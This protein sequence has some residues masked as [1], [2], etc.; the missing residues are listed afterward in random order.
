[1]RKL[2][3]GRVLLRLLSLIPKK[4]P[5]GKLE[6]QPFFVVSAGRSGSN[7][8]NRLL[9]E[10]SQL[11]LPTEQTFLPDL[12]IKFRLYNWILWRDLSKILAGELVLETNTWEN[13]RYQ[14]VFKKIVSAKGTDRHMVKVIDFIFRSFE[15]QLGCSKKYWGDTTHLNLR[16]TKEIY[17]AFPNAKFI[18]LVRDGRDVVA[19]Y[20]E[21]AGIEEYMHLKDHIE[22]AK[23]WE[24]AFST[25]KWLSSKT[26]VHQVKY[27]DL[28]SNPSAVMARVFKFLRVGN[29]SVKDFQ[30]N[31]PDHSFYKEAYHVN[32]KKPISDSSVGKWQSI[33]THEEMTEI[34]PI[35]QKPMEDLG[36]MGN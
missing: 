2:T 12:I 16:Y 15:T 13:F 10:H 3:L 31:I 30:K 22:V 6:K 26:E 24:N 9:N 27:E 33:L 7:L 1:M 17:G 36:Y 11:F 34:T 18:Y 14:E 19:S 20:K 23:N 5:I 28:V 8:L 29:E 35:I 25:Y 32:L 21:G 4:Y